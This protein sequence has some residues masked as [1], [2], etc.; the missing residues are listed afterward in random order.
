MQ[1]HYPNQHDNQ[2]NMGIILYVWMFEN[3][4]VMQYLECLNVTYP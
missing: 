3:A 2:S 4:A 1:E